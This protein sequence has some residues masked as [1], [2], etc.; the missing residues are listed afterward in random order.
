MNE[1]RSC[2]WLEWQSPERPKG[3]G[4]GPSSAEEGHSPHV[5]RPRPGSQTDSPES[6][7][8]QKW[9]KELAKITARKEVMEV[10]LP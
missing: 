9:E 2:W 4:T 10:L 5:G 7:R 8:Q 1:W 6:K 3:S